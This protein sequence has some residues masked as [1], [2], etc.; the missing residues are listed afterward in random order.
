M[1]QHDSN[2]IQELHAWVSGWVQGVGFRDFVIR[3]AL[4]LGL[5]GY[6][7]NDSSGDVEVLAQ[8][9]RAALEQL[10]YLLRRGPSAA[11]VS[12]VRVQWGQPTEYFSGFHI[13]W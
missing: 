11:K 6:T 5:R 7:R 3:K 4:S 2:D 1:S 12:D 13:R 9:K 8:G 10:L